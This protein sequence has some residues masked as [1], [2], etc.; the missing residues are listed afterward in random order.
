MQ[1]FD[2]YNPTHIVFGQDRLA[3]LNTLIPEDAKVMVLYGGG[4]VKRNG[5]LEKV[6][7]GLGKRSVVEYFLE[8]I[9]SSLRNAMTEA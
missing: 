9:I 6:I 2:F 7:A 1:N 5:A 4:S 8:P 3:K